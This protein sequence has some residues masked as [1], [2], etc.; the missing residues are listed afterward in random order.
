MLKMKKCSYF[1][2][3]LC[4]GRASA[5]GH[6]WPDGKH[7][8]VI[9]SLCPVEARGVIA[10]GCSIGIFWQVHIGNKPEASTKLDEGGLLPAWPPCAGPVAGACWRAAG[11]GWSTAE[12]VRSRSYG[13]RRASQMLSSA[14]SQPVCGPLHII[15]SR[16]TGFFLEHKRVRAS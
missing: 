1:A 11:G 7:L 15:P 2:E 10:A 5:Q 6:G 9:I 8:K 4:Q 16:R 14:V 12:A 3:K 13:C